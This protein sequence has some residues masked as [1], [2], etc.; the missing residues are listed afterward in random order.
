MKSSKVVVAVI[1]MIASSVALSATVYIHISGMLDEKPQPRP[2]V[3]FIQDNDKKT[4]TVTAT[5]PG[6]LNWSEFVI[7]WEQSDPI[8]VVLNPGSHYLT[9]GHRMPASDI[10]AGQ[11]I[12]VQSTTSITIRHIDS[13][14][15]IGTW[16]FH[17]SS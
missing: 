7:T 5:Y 3:Q 9:S 11:F 2:T 1:F 12:H 16:S 10:R 13:N 8:Q 14:T 17:D 6:N 4:I 15:L